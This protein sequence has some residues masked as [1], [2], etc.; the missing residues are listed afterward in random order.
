MMKKLK[1]NFPEV[2]DADFQNLIDAFRVKMQEK[3]LRQ[4]E[5]DDMLGA[6]DGFAG[7]YTNIMRIGYSSNI[8]WEEDEYCF[9]CRALTLY[10]DDTSEIKIRRC[11]PC[12]QIVIG[13]QGLRFVLDFKKLTVRSDLSSARWET[14][15]TLQKIGGV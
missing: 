7:N 6:L 10:T 9:R 13:R 15:D 4:N 1:A 14:T 11:R 8:R 12:K 2:S 3:G 5:I